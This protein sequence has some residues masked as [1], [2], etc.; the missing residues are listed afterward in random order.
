MINESIKE[1]IQKY[2]W[3][4]QYVFDANGEKEDFSY[5]IGFEESF[6]HPEII[7][8]GLK[9][10]TMHSILLDIAS[11][12]KQGRRFSENV[13]TGNVLSGELEVL[14]KPVREELLPEYAGI[15]S[16]YYNRPFR[17]MVMFWP[18][19]SNTLPTEAGCT[20][21]AQNEALEIV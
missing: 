16:R 20:L 10:E 19:K 1:N 2:G 14:F 21:T 7:I 6:D 15:A 4:F 8:F 11:D 5:S 12:I 9:R 13:R 3:Q 18:D 17:L